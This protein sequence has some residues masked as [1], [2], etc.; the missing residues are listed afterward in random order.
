MNKHYKPHLQKGQAWCEGCGHIV[1]DW[2]TKPVMH[3]GQFFTVCKPCQL[4]H[5]KGEFI[6]LCYKTKSG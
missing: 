3:N 6:P 5:Q 2:S 1:I 4:L